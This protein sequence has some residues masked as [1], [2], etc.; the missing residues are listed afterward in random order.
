MRG[1]RM[2]CQTGSNFDNVFLFVEKLIRGER[3]QITL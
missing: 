2:F 3:I 1:S